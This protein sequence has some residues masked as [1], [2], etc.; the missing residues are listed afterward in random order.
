MKTFKLNLF[1][2]LW[3]FCLLPSCDLDKIDDA[4]PFVCGQSIIDPRDGKSYETIWIAIDG[5]HNLS[6]SGKCWL[7][8]NLDFNTA[9]FNSNCYNEEE[10]NC[11]T[12]GHMYGELGLPTVCLNGWHIATSAEWSDLYKTYGW[13][14][15]FTGNGPIYSGDS[16]AFLP[17]GT[18]KLNLLMG[19]SCLAIDDCE[20]LGSQVSFWATNGNSFT[21]FNQSGSSGVWSTGV[22]IG[23]PDLRYYVRC[24][25]N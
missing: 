4:G 16:T 6:V 18:T 12:F 3:M 15:Q 2:S 11:T 8:E 14:E 17:G 10:A 19:G 7:A 13:S 1:R 21:Y 22:I 24:V 9:N 25:Q 5:S 23:N 20:G